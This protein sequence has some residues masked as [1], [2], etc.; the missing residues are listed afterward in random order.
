VGDERPV[1][2][3]LQ[4]KVHQFATVGVVPQDVGDV[5]VPLMREVRHLPGEE[6]ANYVGV[7]PLDPD[8]LQAALRLPRSVNEVLMWISHRFKVSCKVV[9]QAIRRADRCSHRRNVVVNPAELAVDC[10]IG[11]DGEEHPARPHVTVLRFTD[12][13][14]VDEANP[15]DVS[16]PRHVGMAEQE[17]ITVRTARNPGQR[18]RVTVSEE[19]FFH[20]PRTPVHHPHP[21][22]VD[23]EPYFRHQR[24]EIRLPLGSHDGPSPRQ[25]LCPRSRSSSLL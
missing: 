5:H 6:E 19:I 11:V 21:H 14:G 17:H 9:G 25:R 10:A 2:H 8:R 1:G 23:V 22:V 7:T 18:G 4:S 12:R 20:P 24:P 15:F 13:A 3:R 16:R